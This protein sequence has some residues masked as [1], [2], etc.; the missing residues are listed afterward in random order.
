MKNLVGMMGVMAVLLVASMARAEPLHTRLPPDT[1]GFIELDPTVVAGPGG[2][3]E[4]GSALLD[5]GVQTL[6]TLGLVPPRATAVADVLA[7][8]AEAGTHHSVMALLDADLRAVGSGR[9]RGLDCRSVQLAWLVDVQ[10][11]P[12]DLLNRLNGTLKVLSTQKTARQS[13]R[14]TAEEKREFVEF[15]DTRW[16]EWLKLCWMQDGELLVLTLGAGAME[17]YLADRPVGGLAWTATLAE[18]D[19]GAAR[20]ELS[21]KIAFHAWV[22]LKTLRERFAEP[23]RKTELGR[24]VAALGLADAEAW[25][26]TARAAGRLLSIDAAAVSGGKLTSVPWTVPNA[27]KLPLAQAVPDD[28]TGYLIAEIE[29]PQLYRR[30]TAIL[31]AVAPNGN[32][33]PAERTVERFCLQNHLDLQKDILANLEPLVLV[34]DSPRHPLRVPFMLTVVGAARPAEQDRTQRASE[35]L[36]SALRA[37][38]ERSAAPLEAPA[39]PGSEY[40]RVHMRADK[41]GIV[42]VQYGL[43]GP[44]WTWSEGRFVYS[45]S[46]AAVRYVLPTLKSAAPESFARPSR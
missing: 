13:V 2:R 25:I 8:I 37:V 3:A 1:L 6:S 14:K 20:L 27:D 43:I 46:P 19:A 7:L 29:W 26:L 10:G 21:G 45:W 30:I 17:H 38:I 22:S 31:D 23:M 18:A 40:T 24:L 44:A 28:A 42:Y 16:P 4:D 39:R 15:Y 35:A 36:F 11:Q 33:L 41:A 32:G 34:H 9:E 12:Q 5:A